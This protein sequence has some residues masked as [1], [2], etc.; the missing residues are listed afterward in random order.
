MNDYRA[1][2]FGEVETILLTTDA[3]DFSAGGVQEAIFFSQAC[4]AKLVVLHVIEIKTEAATAAH[5]SVALKRQEAEAHLAEIEKM[6]KDS[7]I[8]CSIVVSESYQPDRTIIDEAWKANADVIIMGR[9]GRRGLLKLLVGSMTSRI[10]GYGFPKVLVVPKDFTIT[11][12]RI[13]IATDGSEFSKLAAKEA[14]SLATHC[15]NLEKVL[16]VSVA[17]KEE[18]LSLARENANAV[19]EEAK[20]SNIADI[21]EVVAAVGKAGEII[22]QTAETNGADMILIGGFGESGIMKKIMGHVTEDVIGG[23]HCAVLVVEE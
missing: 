17:A 5:S 2:L 4:G 10:I 9:H 22:C 21:F 7:D 8:D 11:G 23:A 20:K 19:V 14:I 16:V 3:S 15:S 12:A 1:K 18:D 13:L 6:A